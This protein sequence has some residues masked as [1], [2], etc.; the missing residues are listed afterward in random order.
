MRFSIDSIKKLLILR[1]NQPL[2]SRIQ[3]SGCGIQGM[4][5]LR[6]GFLKKIIN[7]GQCLIEKSKWWFIL[8]MQY[9]AKSD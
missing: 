6:G 4:M 9:G 2:G 3:D 1:H 7:F 8:S 5:P